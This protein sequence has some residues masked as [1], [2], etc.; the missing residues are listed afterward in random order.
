MWVLGEKIASLITCEFCNEVQDVNLKVIIDWVDEDDRYGDSAAGR[1]KMNC[2]H[3][4]REIIR[5][6]FEE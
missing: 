4:G 1:I 3:C 5:Q 6:R 2:R